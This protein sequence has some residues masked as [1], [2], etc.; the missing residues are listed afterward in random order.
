[1]IRAYFN[2]SD[3]LCGNKLYGNKPQEFISGV[4]T[5]ASIKK[6]A[7]FI[8]VRGLIFNISVEC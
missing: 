5:H 7:S 1:M 4:L 3:K 8:G 2:I 6:E